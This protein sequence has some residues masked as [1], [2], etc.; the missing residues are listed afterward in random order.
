MY[1]KRLMFA[2]LILTLAGLAQGAGP[3]APQVTVRADGTKRLRFD[4]N[5]VPRAN[6]YE[7]WFRANDGATPAKFADLPS[8]RPRVTIGVSIHLLN[9]A[10]ARYWVKACNPGGCTSSTPLAVGA[11]LENAIGFEKSGFPLDL[12]EFGAELAVSADGST[13]VAAAPEEANDRN[14]QYPV[15]ALYVFGR[16][17]ASWQLEARLEPVPA[18]IEDGP[19]LRLAIDADGSRF[20]VGMPNYVSNS[21][22]PQDDG[23]ALIYERTTAGWRI[24]QRIA[25][26]GAVATGEIADIDAAGNTALFGTSYPYGALQVWRRDASGWS[27]S[28]TVPYPGGSATCRRAALSADG[29]VIARACLTSGG[30]EIQVFTG[31]SWAQRNRIAFTAPGADYDFSGF[32]VDRD[33]NT[34]AAAFARATDGP[35]SHAL[36]AVFHRTTGEYRREST[37]TPGGWFSNTRSF[38]AQF[39]TALALSPDGRFLAVGHPG[40]DGAGRGVLTPPLAAGGPPI[41]AVYL[42]ERINGGWRVRNVV[43]PDYQPGRG[44]GPAFGAAVSF[45]DAGRT[46]VIGQPG[47]STYVPNPNNYQD[48]PNGVASGALW[49]Y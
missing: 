30:G 5:Y 6:Y 41:G 16:A 48:G 22:P 44:K 8:W 31:A 45:G 35:D 11:V 49:I 27:L 36:A 25:P 47:E 26:S 46:L 39:G 24:A 33:A 38:D 1:S 3:A 21:G 14:V 12:A 7:L 32:A 10:Q 2:C 4:W 18:Q 29:L 43:K 23:Q 15:A 20:I 40:D 28:S 37:F 13:L 42:C 17:G 19:D 9:W 34:I